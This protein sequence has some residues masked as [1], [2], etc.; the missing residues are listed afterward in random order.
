MSRTPPYYPRRFGK[1]TAQQSTVATDAAS[2]RVGIHISYL[3]YVILAEGTTKHDKKPNTR[4][5]CL[6]SKR[7]CKRGSPCQGKSVGGKLVGVVTSALGC[8]ATWQAV[9]YERADGVHF[10]PAAILK[11]KR[12]TVTL[13]IL[14]SICASTIIFQTR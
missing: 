8:E 4:F 14:W 1:T 5:K 7:K 2:K 3:T 9:P 6:G 13:V 12:S 11:V 10:L